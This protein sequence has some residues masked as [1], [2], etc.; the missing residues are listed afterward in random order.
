MLDAVA[1]LGIDERRLISLFIRTHFFFIMKLSATTLRIAL[2]DYRA[3]LIRMQLKFP[4][5]FKN[6]EHDSLI[7]SID[8]VIYE[9]DGNITEVMISPVACKANV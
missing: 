7:E 1:G 6:A 9:I 4:S 5:S 2:I 8:N 3:E